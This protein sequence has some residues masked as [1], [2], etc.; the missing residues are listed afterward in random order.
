MSRT[1][2]IDVGVR[3]QILWVGGEAYPLHN[4][5]RAMTVKLVPRRGSAVGA[6][7]RAVLL[8]AFLG[9]GGVVALRY[10][11]LSRSDADMLT[12][13]L[14]LG[15]VAL[16]AVSTIKLLVALARPTL[17]ALVIET[18]GTPRTAVVS[19]NRA[20]LNQLVEQI[21]DAINNPSTAFNVQVEN[22]YGGN[23]VK[24]YGS[25]NVGMV[26]R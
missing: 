10:A 3:R 2:I 8:W 24:Q 22:Y 5:A 20:L 15:A 17:Y 18:A 23:H 13:Y 4:I 11:E 1:E 14:A 9:L 25:Q 7:V 6:F 16:M 19:P 21:M 26:N 12:N